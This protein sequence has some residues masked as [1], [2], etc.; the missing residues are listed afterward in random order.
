MGTKAKLRELEDLIRAFEKIVQDY[1]HSEAYKD[2]LAKLQQE[3]TD[4]VSKIGDRKEIR[5]R[6]GYSR[7]GRNNI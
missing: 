4:L 7:V 6:L 2:S 5:S 1:P 3:R